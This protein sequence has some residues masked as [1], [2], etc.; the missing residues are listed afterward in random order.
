MSSNRLTKKTNTLSFDCG[1]SNLAYCLVEDVNTPDN[2][3][4]IRMWENFSLNT[5]DLSQAIDNLVSELDSRPWMLLADHICIESQLQVNTTMKALSHAIQTYFVTRSRSLDVNESD[6]ATITTRVG[7]RVHFV[8]PQSKF[9][10]C[11]V[12][13]PPSGGPGHSRNKKVAIAMAK[14]ILKKERDMTSLEYMESHKKQ[15]DLADSFLQGIYF[16]RSLRKKQNLNRKIQKHLGVEKEIIIREESDKDHC[17][18]PFVYRSEDFIVPE[19][20]V[21][22]RSISQS[23]KYSRADK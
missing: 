22:P 21:D 15:D 5:L 7:P 11:S 14:K 17:S 19:F 6:S 10:V 20:N 1:L 9:K 16:L 12:P 23:T 3:V 8:V 13:E 4:K 2:E 18:K